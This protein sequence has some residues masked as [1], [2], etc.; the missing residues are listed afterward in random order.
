MVALITAAVVLVAVNE[1]MFPEPDTAR[2]IAEFVLAHVIEAPE[3][4]ELRLI[5][6]VELP[7]QNCKSFN[8]FTRGVGLMV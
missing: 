3:G 8:A 2:P 5:A 6:G 4:V 7:L 1:A